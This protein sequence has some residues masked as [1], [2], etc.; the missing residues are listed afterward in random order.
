MITKGYDRLLES[1]FY[2]LTPKDKEDDV[3]TD[4]EFCCFIDMFH[5]ELKETG[6]LIHGNFRWQFAVPAVCSMIELAELGFHIS[7]IVTAVSKVGDSVVKISGRFKDK[8]LY[9]I[10]YN[11]EKKIWISLKEPLP[12]AKKTS[13]VRH[14]FLQRKFFASDGLNA[15]LY[16]EKLLSKTM[17]QNMRRILR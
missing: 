3:V 2:I 17:E 9:I 16:L 13:R 1:H 12:G 10:F 15:S 4:P 5:K 11:E 8:T 7:F 6:R 14:T